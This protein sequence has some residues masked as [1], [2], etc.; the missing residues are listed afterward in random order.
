MT[1]MPSLRPALLALACAACVDSPRVLDVVARTVPDTTDDIAA[2]HVR[3]ESRGVVRCQA[4][5]EATI[6]LP[7]DRASDGDRVVVTAVDGGGAVLAVGDTT[8]DGD[9][10]RVELTAAERALPRSIE[11]NRSLAAGGPEAGRQLALGEHGLAAVVWHEPGNEYRLLGRVVNGP[12]GGLDHGL[13]TSADLRLAQPAIAGLP[14][15]FVAAWSDDDA[16]IRVHGLGRD[17]EPLFPYGDM[18]LAA[19]SEDRRALA[20]TLIAAGDRV[21]ALW[22]DTLRGELAG[23]VGVRWIDADGN[24]VGDTRHLAD[25]TAFQHSATAAALPSGDLVLGWLEDDRGGG[26][27]STRLRLARMPA[28]GGPDLASA[29]TV[30]LAGATVDTFALAPLGDR[31]AVAWDIDGGTMHLAL[32]DAALRQVGAVVD[33]ERPHQVRQVALVRHGDGLLLAWVERGPNL[34]HTAWLRWL[35]PDGLPVGP[36]RPASLIAGGDQRHLSIAANRT[37]AAFVAWE[38]IAAPDR[39]GGIVGRPIA[40]DDTT[41]AP[42]PCNAPG[43]P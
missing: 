11:A 15:G 41:A 43:A 42:A 26:I 2:Y 35:G 12:P 5:D 6:A 20:P 14:D 29:V 3:V 23:R 36:A 1:P 28:D 34:V 32:F 31:L 19:A 18:P 40:P 17:L 22:N 4:F 13:A 25:L 30:D 8:V 37:G 9:D 27:G 38:Q 7:T 24:P 39:D 33:L 21:L 10:L 16:A